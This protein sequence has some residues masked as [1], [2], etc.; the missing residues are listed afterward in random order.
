MLTPP[1]TVVVPTHNRPELMQKAVQS[2]LSQDY[3]GDIEVIVVFD[4]CD[5]ALP[6]ISVA[7]RRSLRGI[8]NERTRGLA[9]GRNTGIM[10]ASSE[11]IAS[12]DDDDYWFADKLTEQMRVMQQNPQTYLV[13]S[14]ML[15]ERGEATHERLV[16]VDVVHHDQLLH[17]RMAGLHS[18]S[19]LFRRS[20]LVDKIGLIDEELPASYGEDYDVLLRT[21]KLSPI[22]V[23]N[24]PLLTVRW[25]GQ[26]YFFGK[27]LT[28]ADGL[29]YLLEKHPDFAKHKKSH[30]RI[31]SQIAFALAAGKEHARA[32]RMALKALKDNP[33]NIK[34]ALALA[35]GC[36]LLS[37]AWV[38]KT[39][40]RMGKGI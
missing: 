17:D 9:G 20:A 37:A 3:A 14:A 28:Y 24:K 12:L 6:E 2:V 15:V 19:F 33:L 11:F 1:V 23:V 34:A 22:L 8:P 30:S 27:W 40:Q 39:V 38:I 16:P 5:V 10:N 29:S 13:G 21:A 35:I 31:N 18:S 25:S 4:A 32:R 36:H 7:D 26:S